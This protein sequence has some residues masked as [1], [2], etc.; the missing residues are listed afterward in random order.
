MGKLLI[1]LSLLVFNATLYAQA[2]GQAIY[3]VKFDIPSGEVLKNIRYEVLSVTPTIID[4]LLARL[5][6]SPEDNQNLRAETHKGVFINGDSVDM[7]PFTG[8]R[9]TVMTWEAFRDSVWANRLWGTGLDSATENRL[10]T[11]YAALGQSLQ[12]TA[13]DKGLNEFKFQ[14]S[15]GNGVIQFP[16]DETY[17]RLFLLKFTSGNHSGYILGNLFGGCN[18]TI[19]IMQSKEGGFRKLNNPNS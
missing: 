19:H 18:R 6:P 13:R 15:A 2:C 14:G 12:R 4:S 7:R 17:E 8:A 1:A 16:T 9:P 5:F 3:T 11:W 10:Q